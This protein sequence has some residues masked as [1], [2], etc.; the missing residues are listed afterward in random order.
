MSLSTFSA[1]QEN[2]AYEPH[3]E[4]SGGFEHNI[5]TCQGR[6]IASE[7]RGGSVRG[8]VVKGGAVRGGGVRGGGVRGGGVRGGGVRGWQDNK[9]C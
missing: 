8:G 3:H 4:V 5:R 1:H 2:V 6:P 7:T 9:S